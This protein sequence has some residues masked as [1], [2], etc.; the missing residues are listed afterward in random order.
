MVAHISL[1]ISHPLIAEQACGWD[2][3]TITAGS[4]KKVLWQCPVGDKHKY[5]AAVANRTKP[6]KMTGCPYCTNT[7]VLVGFNDL[8]FTHPQIAEQACGWDT[9]TVTAGSEKQFLWQ[10]PISP[11][12]KYVS[13]VCSRTRPKATGCPYCTGRLIL[14]GFNDLQFL[15][16][17]IAEQA[18]GWDPTIVSP[19]SVKRLLWQCPIGENH[20]YEA[21]VFAR[22]KG[23]GCPYC[24]GHKILVGFNDLKFTHP[25][26]AE[27][28]D[29]WDPT[30]VSA[31]AKRKLPWQC[32]VAENH[33]YEAEVRNRTV[34][35]NGCPYCSGRRLM[36]GF[37]DLKFT[38]PT[39]AEQACG[40]DPTTVSAGVAGKF[41]WQCQAVE[42]H[43]FE[44][45]ISDRVNGSDCNICTRHGFQSSRPAVFYIHSIWEVGHSGS[46]YAWKIGITNRPSEF[47]RAKQELSLGGRYTV[48][49]EYEAA[50][51]GAEAQRLE[52]G[53]LFLLRRQ[54]HLNP[55]F[56]Q[57]EM[58]DGFS[59]TVLASEI[60]MESLVAYTENHL[61]G[62]GILQLS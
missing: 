15:H 6:A 60:S 11:D 51:S 58:R 12:H 55:A 19:G 32:P 9:T 27:Q 38:H 61:A 29:G 43:K 46:P 50:M 52:N 26:I 39:I 45:R 13:R 14:S 35:G 16:P 59:E 54:L 17:L 8:A 53:M 10:C 31:R 37:N 47:R 25:V 42:S 21:Q 5:I 62:K 4:N 36:V 28:A 20:K 3:T 40:W 49:S 30:T 56:L 7:K 18:S 2:P 24:S 48:R 33:K 23:Y 41:L 57:R 1:A 22:V 34:A 44:A